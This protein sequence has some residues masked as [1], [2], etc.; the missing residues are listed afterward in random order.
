MTINVAVVNVASDTFQNWINKF[1]NV[2]SAANTVFLTTDLTSTGSITTGNAV[3]NGQL[4]ASTLVG[5]TFQGGTIG[6]P[7]VATF[8]SNV[9]VGNS[10]V[11]TQLGSALVN[12]G[13][14]SLNATAVALGANVALT[15]TTLSIGNST[16]NHSANSILVSVANST[17][18][19]NLSPSSL[20]SGNTVV[21]TTVVAVGANASLSS[22]SLALGNST[23]NL[24]AN[25][26]TLT[27][28]ANLSI[29]AATVQVGNSTANQVSNSIV[30]QLANSTATSRH[31]PGVVNVGA[32]VWVNTT[33]VQVGANVQLGEDFL[34]IGNA[35]INLF[36]NSSAVLLSGNAISGRITIQQAGV[37]K[38]TQPVLNF[39][40]GTGISVTAAND[41]VD[42]QV[43]VT[44]TATGSATTNAAGSNTDIQFNDSGVT[45]GNDA[46]TFVKTTNTV[47]IT[48]TGALT[49]GS[50]VV[51]NS[52]SLNVGNS[53]VSVFVNSSLLEVSNS[54]ATANYSV[55]GMV[56]GTTIANGTVISL[57]ANVVANATVVSIGN[58]SVNVQINSTALI[59]ATLLLG[60]GNSFTAFVSGTTTGTTSQNV[61]TWS[62]GTYRAAKYLVTVKDNV[63]NAYQLTE[64]YV[65][66]DGTNALITEIVQMQSNGSMGTLAAGANSTVVSLQF[67][68]VSANTTVKADRILIAQ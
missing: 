22:S 55:A 66:F 48:G 13:G 57:G 27:I 2:A 34:S 32:N 59:G 21:N 33:S 15:T 39:I 46:F 35:T 58:S 3:V 67:T 44:I 19:L 8:S 51:V 60:G 61:D 5:A 11:N 40:G 65:L 43:N 53:T 42:G 26:L 28:G 31:G 10:T 45:N 64:C 54:T 36:A 18:G 29:T 62:A 52:S 14:S 38:G 63:S 20:F 12:V 4:Q 9:S 50:N 56:V 24:F 1:N 23:V 6:A 68:P 16:A 47:A 41:S 25:S 17:F 37:V 7:A 30:V 49:L